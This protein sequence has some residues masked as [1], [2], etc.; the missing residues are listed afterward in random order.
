MIKMLKKVNHIGIVVKN[1]EE[2]IAAYSKGLGIEPQT[3][4]EIPDVQLKVCVLRIGEV[5]IELLHYGNPKMPVVNSLR[6]GQEGLNHVCYEVEGF[7]EAMNR[8]KI[9]RASCRERV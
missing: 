8:L 4:T 6:G 3:I 5:E 2:A 7:E 1:F 9:G